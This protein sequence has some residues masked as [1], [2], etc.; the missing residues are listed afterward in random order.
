[1]KYIG[2]DLGSKTLGIALSDKTGVIASTYKTI[3]FKEDNYDELLSQ[4][5]TIIQNHQIDKVIL[6][7]PKNMNNTIGKR[8]EKTLQFKDKLEKYLNKKII[9]E[10]ERWTTIQA[11]NILLQ[12]DLSRKKRKKTVDKV[13]AV[14][15]LQNYLNKKRK[16]E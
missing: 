1:M 5:K 6:G 2:L 14:F 4:I 13:A 16:E 8:A 9:L 7:L 3:N 12:A 10:D 15:I 11:N